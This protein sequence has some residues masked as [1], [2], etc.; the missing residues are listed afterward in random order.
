MRGRQGVAFPRQSSLRVGMETGSPQALGSRC[1][2]PR[3]PG[4]GADRLPQSSPGLFVLGSAGLSD[5]SWK[6]VF[7]SH[8]TTTRA[9]WDGASG[10]R[11]RGSLAESR[12]L[13]FPSRGLSEPLRQEPRQKMLP[14][15]DPSRGLGE[16]GRRPSGGKNRADNWKRK[17]PAVGPRSTQFR[18]PPPGHSLKY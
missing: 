3:G 14:H 17:R 16:G 18:I 2:P 9:R 5:F 8:L 10:R 11:G 4:G 1:W 13:A 6:N 7:C 12:P 15:P